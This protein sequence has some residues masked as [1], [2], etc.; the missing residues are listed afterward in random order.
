MFE[1]SIELFLT[2]KQ[3]SEVIEYNNYTIGSEVYCPMC[4]DMHENNTLC[5][6]QPMNHGG[7]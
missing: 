6:M 7:F 1:R 3:V 2:K 4:E 5:Q